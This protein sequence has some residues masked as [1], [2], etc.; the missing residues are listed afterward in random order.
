M[1]TGIYQR[2]KGY[3]RLPLSDETK[4]KISE[5][6]KG[7]KHCLGKKLSEEHKRKIGLGNIG[8]KHLEEI[9]KKISQSHKGILH[10]EETKQKMSLSKK[11]CIPWNKGKKGVQIGWNKGK[12]M[13][14]PAW[15]KGIKIPEF[16]GENHP[17]WINDRSKLKI[18]REKAYDTQYKYWMLEVKKRDNWKCKIANQDC[19][20]KLE[21]HHILGW[22][23]HPELRYQLN[24][25]ITLCHAHH[26]RKRDE[27]A[28]LS[29]YFKSLVAEMK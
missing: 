2:K 26:P 5:S 20:G 27:E 22:K 15:N 11:G 16:S 10:T 6:L 17:R 4:L 29:P 1:P 19:K 13:K 14:Y 21:A 12:K 28:K 24:N 9:R 3:K 7:N 8:K 23:S 18:D 25:G